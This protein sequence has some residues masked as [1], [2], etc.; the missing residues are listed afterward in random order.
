VGNFILRE[1]EI[2]R[3]KKEVIVLLTLFAVFCLSS[4]A[5]AVDCPIPDTGQTKCYDH[6]QEIVCPRPGEPFY[7]QDANYAPCNPHSYT[8]L[9]ENSNALP[10]DAT[11]WVMVR[12]NV[13]GLICEN[14][15]DDGSIHDKDDE[16]NWYD[17][18]NVFI[19]TLN[20]QNF[21][22]HNDWRLPT[23]K[24]LTSIIDNNRY[25]PSI[26]TTYF[27]NTVSSESGYWSSTTNAYDPNSAWGIHF[28]NGFG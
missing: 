3:T 15:T 24:E 7:G 5:L 22:G 16:Y 23:V 19:A 8:K 1:G 4:I 21:G 12:D 6:T 17:S 2:M 11:E 9:D 27:A 26:N 18:Q 20:S 13:T 10:D 25:A 14:K 28:Y